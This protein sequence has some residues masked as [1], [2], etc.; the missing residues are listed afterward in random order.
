M[1][2]RLLAWDSW[3][4]LA[5]EAPPGKFETIEAQGDKPVTA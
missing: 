5:R 2:K 4:R 1:E 3:T